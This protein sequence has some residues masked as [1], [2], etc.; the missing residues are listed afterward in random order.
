M[1][2]E[3]FTRTFEKNLAR[4]PLRELS[5]A[6][7]AARAAVMAIVRR[8]NGGVEICFIKRS[9]HPLDRFSG[10]IAFPGGAR[11]ENDPDMLATAIRETREETGMEVENHG[12]ILGRLDDETPRGNTDKNRREYLVNVFVCALFS[13]TGVSDLEMRISDDE[14]DEIFWIPA[15]EL[16]RGGSPEKPE[17]FHHERRIWGMTARIVDKLLECIPPQA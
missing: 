14:V 17:F 5:L 9:R 4:R 11:E 12:K 8:A 1:S 2:D 13:D 6:N 15:D 10:H 7:G 3:L 16:R